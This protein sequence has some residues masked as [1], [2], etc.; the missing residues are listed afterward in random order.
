MSSANVGAARSSAGHRRTGTQP[1]A[2]PRLRT[3][4][5]SFGG[6]PVIN[7]V[8]LEVGGAVG[9][10]VLAIRPGL[11]PVSATV[12]LLAAMLAGLRWHGRWLPMWIV[13]V[14]R[15]LLR[16]RSKQT[17]SAPTSADLPE[18]NRTGEVSVT[19]PEDTRVAALRLLVGDLLVV[20]RT[21]HEQFP[22]GI[23]WHNGTWTA[24]LVIDPL[25]AMVSPVGANTEVPL[26][27]LAECLQDRGVVL[28]AIGVVWHCYPAGSRLPPGSAVLEAYNEVL[29]PLPAV[30]QRSTWVTLRLDPRRCPAAVR[31]R[32]GGVAGAHRALLGAVSRV[33][34]VLDHSGLNSH[35]LGSDELLRAASSSAELSDAVGAGAA[36]GLREHWAGVDSGG[37][38]H[39]SYGIDSWPSDTGALNLLTSIRA[40]ST[41]VALALSPAAEESTVAMRGVVRVS[42]RTTAELEAARTRVAALTASSGMRLSPLNG[43]QAAAVAATL[44]IGVG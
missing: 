22:I 20:S 6:I 36:V 14:A 10:T 29:G 24:V 32:G 11:W 8:V 35:V 43:Q 19:G 38:V 41:T 12:L 13:V 30:A 7:V 18:L 23:A 1:S 4:G 28:D 33:R 26:S 44:P 34:G 3:V 16:E 2:A 31:E 27:A 37:V 15:F 25:P 5:A 40:M 17:S 9:L 39:S 21:D 42:A